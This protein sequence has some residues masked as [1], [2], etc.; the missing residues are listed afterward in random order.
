MTDLARA[1]ASLAVAAQAAG[2]D[3][4]V[5]STIRTVA[6]NLPVYSGLVQTATFNERQ[7]LLPARRGLHRRSQQPDA[8]RRSSRP[9]PACTTSR[10]GG[11][12]SDQDN[13]VSSPSAGGRL[14]LHR[15]ALGAP[16]RG[17]GL[18]EPALSPDLQRVPGWWRRSS[19]SSSASGSRS[20]WSPRAPSVN[21]ATANGSGPVVVFT[22][23]RIGALQM[24][25]DDELTLLTRDSVPLVPAG[26][27]QDRRPHRPAAG[28][29]PATAPGRWRRGR[30]RGRRPALAA[31]ARV[32]GA[33]PAR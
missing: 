24:T 19:W 15:G 3:P 16:H 7:A 23:A 10:T 31:Y 6:V 32:H 30:S 5:A 22:Q 8:D 13:A 21:T 14:S 9:L 20:P 4:A 17:A 33:D 28:L 18:D 12:R 11:W 2:G 1:S 27:R 25:A 26:L 29:A